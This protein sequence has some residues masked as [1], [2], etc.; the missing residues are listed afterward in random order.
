MNQ[1][2]SLMELID[3]FSTYSNVIFFKQ[4]CKKR[5]GTF[6]LHTSY[7]QVHGLQSSKLIKWKEN[8][9]KSAVTVVRKTSSFKEFQWQFKERMH[10][11]LWMSTITVASNFF[12][13][14][15]CKAELIK[16][17]FPHSNVIKHRKNEDMAWNDGTTLKNQ[18]EKRTSFSLN[19]MP[20]I[21]TIIFTFI[22]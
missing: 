6:E 20:H 8:V 15:N 9:M 4:L 7:N 5:R 1:I 18:R 14:R 12:L 3:E 11:V 16:Y 19:T 21:Y 22:N 13:L 17:V 10:H 2:D